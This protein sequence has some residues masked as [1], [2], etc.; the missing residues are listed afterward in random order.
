VKAFQGTRGLPVTGIVN[1]TTW[2]RLAPDLGLGAT[3]EAVRAPQVE[4]VEK[5]RAAV[6]I[7][8]VFGAA[9]RTAVLTFQGHLGLPRS[10]IVDTATWRGL[11]W[12]YELPR[13]G[14]TSL[15]DYSVGNGPANWG[16]AEAIDTLE[17]VGRSI[18]ARGFGRVAVG[19]ISLEHGGNI[20]GHETHER[21]LDVDVRPLRK[22]NDQCSV[23][24]TRWSSTAYDR[25]ATRAMIEAFRAAAPGHVKL[26][27]FND[28]VLIREGL[29]RWFSGHDDHVHVRFCERIH[30]LA[31]YDC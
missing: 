6:P 7:D 21:G 14:A 25:A 11:T 30:P 24:G 2:A 1:G 27:Y 29:T 28:P 10:G 4:L 19:D 18:V 31:A 13:F 16:T 17:A 20:A 23:A 12:H 5:R 8:G 9:T 26:I 22:A 15:C 3:G